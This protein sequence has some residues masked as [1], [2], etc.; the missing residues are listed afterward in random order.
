V[1]D[2]L[3]LRVAERTQELQ[4]AN[5]ELEAFAYSVSHDL[6]APLRAASGFAQLLARRHAGG[7]DDE[8]RHF[9]DNIV[10]SSTQMGRL[11]DDLLAYSRVGRRAVR[12]EP[13]ELGP[14]VDRMRITFADR[15]AVP[16][17]SLCAA[18]PLATPVGD[19]TL[20]EQVLA[21]FVG[22]ALTYCQPGVPPD[23]RIVARPDRGGVTIRVTD[24][25][26]GIA[27][28]H[29]ERIFEVFNRLHADEEYSGT[30]IG[31]AI[32]RKAAR[33]LDGEISVESTVG[34]GSTFSLYLPQG[35][36]RDDQD[37]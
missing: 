21:N 19:P 37:A 35:V 20:V 16:G 15:L 32:A 2:A 26:I 17:A 3:E 8:G 25:G 34:A 5:T 27:P 4:E 10:A 23:V 9:I 7:L 12:R 22:N 6:R 36:P 33:L 14:I 13:V 30:G 28:E 31:L 29:L 18:E 1:A 11:I 24:T